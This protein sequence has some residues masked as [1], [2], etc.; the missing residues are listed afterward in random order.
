MSIRWSKERLALYKEAVDEQLG[1][2]RLAAQQL[3][4]RESTLERA[5]RHSRQMEREGELAN[6]DPCNW[7]WVNEGLEEPNRPYLLFSD[8]HAPYAAPGTIEFLQ[9]VSKEYDCQER[10]YCLGDLYD[11]HSMSRHTTELDSPSPDAEYKRAKEWVSKLAEA[12]PV[13]TWVLGN[14]DCIPQ[15][16]LKTLNLTLDLL[17]QNNE[18]Y[19]VPDTWTIE[20]LFAVLKAR[21][22]DMLLEHG[23]GSNGCNGAI[24]SAVA[25]GS[26]Y[27]QGHMHA[28]ASVSYRAC[29]S[30]LKIGINTGCLADNGSLAMRY[31]RYSKNKG[32][33]GCALVY[34]ATDKTAATAMFV[35]M[36]LGGK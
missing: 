21:G 13:A 33:V 4:I 2:T 20:P 36:N 8:P 32:V 10:V 27:A 26:S 34:P 22:L 11:F 5:L 25:K 16:Q 6:G 30:D 35:P 31:G 19:N 12:F 18:L 15:R 28:F 9:W 7:E 3:G 29:H 14:H 1:D 17:K 24:N 23:L